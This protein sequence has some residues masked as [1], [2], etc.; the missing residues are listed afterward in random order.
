LRFVNRT[1]INGATVRCSQKMAIARWRRELRRVDQ[2]YASTAGIVPFGHYRS[3]RISEVRA[4]PG[5]Q[6]RA[7]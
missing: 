7:K 4:G 1:K 3:F 6:P 5:V 2:F